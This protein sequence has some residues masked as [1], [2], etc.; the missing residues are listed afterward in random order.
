LKKQTRSSAVGKPK[1]SEDSHCY[2]AKSGEIWTSPPL[3]KCY[4][5]GVRSQNIFLLLH[6]PG[7]RIQS[8]PL[9]PIRKSQ[10]E[11][12]MVLVNINI[13]VRRILNQLQTFQIVR[14]SVKSF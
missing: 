9:F 3:N 6:P 11:Q 12:M 2:F 8:A 5:S 7:A 10:S 13:L 1:H 14:I 4:F